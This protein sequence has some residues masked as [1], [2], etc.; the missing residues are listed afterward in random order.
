MKMNSEVN[1]SFNGI[2]LASLE[3]HGSIGFDV[4][5]CLVRYK[6]KA[7]TRICYDALALTLVQEK[8]YPESLREVTD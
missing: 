8:G 1:Q 5:H 2:K 7:L 3:N 4:D 6:I